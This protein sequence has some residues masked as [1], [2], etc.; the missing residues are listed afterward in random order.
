M[1]PKITAA[2]QHQDIYLARIGEISLKGLNRGAF[3]RRLLENL[4]RRLRPLGSFLVDLAQ[5]RLWII[6]VEDQSA[7]D[8][9]QNQKILQA[10][11]SVFGIVSASPVWRF[12]GGMTELEGQAV[13]FVGQ[14]LADGRPRT[15]KVE[16]RRGN[17]QFPLQSPEI[18]SRVGEVVGA[19][20]PEQLR[21][22]VHHPDF[23][24]YVE[25][26]DQIC[27]YSEVIKGQKGLPVGTG[28]RGMLLLSGGI[29]SPVAGY[30][31][32]SRGMELQA[33]YFHAYPFTSDR[34]R[35]KVV[36][37]GRQLVLYSGRLKLHVVDFTDIQLTLRD[38]CPQEL[39]T[40]I[41][42][43]MM[44]RIAEKLALQEGCQALITGESLGQVASQTVEA[45]QVTGA[46]VSLPLLRPL[47][48]IDK[49]DTITIARRIGTFD[50]SILPFEDC[51]TIFVAKHPKIHPHIAEVLAAE[52]ALDVNAL[53]ADGLARIS[54]LDL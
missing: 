45:I 40:I 38:Q 25:V 17:K 18:S 16:S 12:P 9:A 6:P 52:A 37:L 11:T 34:A 23:I 13:A 1:T 3:E 39:L 53:T 43:R 41:M 20:F 31:M 54:T 7:G 36:E 15:F 46:V 32:A 42:R 8:A 10:I 35:D 44:L 21:V 27:L 19:A 14:I 22:D 24:V 5:S 30:M 28:G 47:I 29:D 26:R 50:T 48:G 33:V 51:C 49:D 4:K 2:G